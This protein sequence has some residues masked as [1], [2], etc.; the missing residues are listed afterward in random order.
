MT[1][2][3]PKKS[4]SRKKTVQ[5]GGLSSLCTEG[6]EG[7]AID[8][9]KRFS[10]DAIMQIIKVK[11]EE[12]PKEFDKRIGQNCNLSANFTSLKESLPTL[13]PQT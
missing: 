11:D 2:A 3:L 1:I 7:P 10:A 13:D 4:I 8:V 6:F 12:G 5:L 9:Q